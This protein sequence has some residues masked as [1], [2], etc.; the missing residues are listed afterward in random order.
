MDSTKNTLFKTSLDKN[1][2]PPDSASW[3]PLKRDV[4][5]FYLDIDEKIITDYVGNKRGHTSQGIKGK[6]MFNSQRIVSVKFLYDQQQNHIFIRSIVRKS[7]AVTLQYVTVYIKFIPICG[8]IGMKPQKAYCECLIGKSGVCCHTVA[9][10]YMLNSYTNKVIELI[11][12]PCTSKLKLGIKNLQ[13]FY[14]IL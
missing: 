10:L 13:N 8:I 11:Q 2:I 7:Y 1:T 6:R 3:K 4:L 14:H 12:T 5:K 9:S